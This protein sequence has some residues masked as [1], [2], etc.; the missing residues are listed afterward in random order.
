MGEMVKMTFQA[1]LRDE[2]H[3]V[4]LL[5]QMNATDHFVLGENK[6]REWLVVF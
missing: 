4:A 1:R 5:F 6:G 2:F 3:H